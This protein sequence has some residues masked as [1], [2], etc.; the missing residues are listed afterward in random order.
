MGYSEAA[1]WA[2]KRGDYDVLATAEIQALI[3]AEEGEEDRNLFYSSRHLKT[4]KKL[5]QQRRRKGPTLLDRANL[6]REE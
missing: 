6:E 1:W 4:L 5:L 2:F 3:K